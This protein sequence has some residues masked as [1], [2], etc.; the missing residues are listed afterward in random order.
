MEILYFLTGGGLVLI[1]IVIG[2]AISSGVK[3]TNEE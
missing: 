3:K 1:G 2:A